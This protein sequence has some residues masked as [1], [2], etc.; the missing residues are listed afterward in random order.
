MKRFT[1]LPCD[2][3]RVRSELVSMCCEP[4]FNML[5]SNSVTGGSGVLSESSRGESEMVIILELCC[6]DTFSTNE[7][8]FSQ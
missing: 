4:L 5:N 2:V 8:T 7:T 3:V 6:V 1:F